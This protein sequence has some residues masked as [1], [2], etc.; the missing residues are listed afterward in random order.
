MRAT[1]GKCLLTFRKKSESRS[2]ETFARDKFSDMTADG[3][4]SAQTLYKLG[5]DEERCMQVDA[6]H[7]EDYNLRSEAWL[8]L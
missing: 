5:N 8:V 1:S 4:W 7:I 3:V 6:K 2:I